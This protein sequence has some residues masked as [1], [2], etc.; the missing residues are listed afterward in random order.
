MI[1]LHVMVLEVSESCFIYYN[2]KV[3]IKNISKVQFHY[4]KIYINQFISYNQFDE[5]GQIEREK[6]YANNVLYLNEYKN[7]IK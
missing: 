5:T 7:K 2:F 3:N 4:Y 1:Y 6:F